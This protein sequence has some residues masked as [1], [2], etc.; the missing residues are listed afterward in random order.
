MKEQKERNIQKEE[1]HSYEKPRVIALKL[2]ADQVLGGNCY[3][4]N[5]G[6]G[7]DQAAASV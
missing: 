1:K 7:G 3:D 4:G 6:C 5:Q 2:L